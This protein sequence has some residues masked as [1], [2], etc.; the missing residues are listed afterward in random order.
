MAEIEPD[1]SR[2]Q[3]LLMQ[4]S[5]LQSQVQELE[6]ERGDLV[7]VVRHQAK[8]ID[9]LKRQR[10]HVEAATLLDISETEFRRAISA[11][12]SA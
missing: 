3:G 9:L 2:E 1:I 10:L 4:I 5:V 11:N 6:R 12:S 8:L 7:T